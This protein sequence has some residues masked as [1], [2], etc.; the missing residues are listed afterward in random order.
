MTAVL[1]FLRRRWRWLAGSFVVAGLLQAIRS[2]L[3][4]RKQ[5]LEA[6]ARAA[7]GAALGKAEAQRQATHDAKI[8]GLVDEAKAPLQ[9]EAASIQGE[10][11][12]E[13][14]AKAKARIAEARK[15]RQR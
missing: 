9:V 4:A 3:A 8:D 1:A 14:T 15:E 6:E 7:L 10:S 2:V 11:D 13:A 12:H 5:R